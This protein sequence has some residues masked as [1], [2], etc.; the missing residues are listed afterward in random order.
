MVAQV[1]FRCI[2]NMHVPYV[3]NSTAVVMGLSKSIYPPSVS[4]TDSKVAA[5]LTTF[6]AHAGVLYSVE[7]ILLLML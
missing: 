7:S 6:A 1:F 3:Y 4:N 5:F 2:V